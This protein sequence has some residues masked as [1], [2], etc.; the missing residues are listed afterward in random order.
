LRSLF[1][2]IGKELPLH[3]KRIDVAREAAK[4]PFKQQQP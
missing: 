4:T 2:T 3:L 1:D